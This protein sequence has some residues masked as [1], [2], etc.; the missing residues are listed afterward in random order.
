MELFL[1]YFLAPIIV[2][3]MSRYFDERSHKKINEK[4]NVLLNG[5]ELKRIFDE[6]NR[7]HWRDQGK[8]HE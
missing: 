6:E 3:L 7:K 8:N 2:A 5:K 4:L 1:Q